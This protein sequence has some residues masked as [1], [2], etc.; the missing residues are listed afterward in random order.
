LK[1]FCYIEKFYFLSDDV[2]QSKFEV[3]IEIYSYELFN[4]ANNILQS[5]RKLAKQFADFATFKR[6]SQQGTIGHNSGQQ[7]PYLNLANSTNNYPQSIHKFKLIA[8]ASLNQEDLC[9]QIST[10]CLKL[11]NDS[12]NFWHSYSVKLMIFEL[13]F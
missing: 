8:R 2:R 3:L 12:S 13:K 11:V 7:Q 6:N 5:A 10:K 4:A 1:N 9:D